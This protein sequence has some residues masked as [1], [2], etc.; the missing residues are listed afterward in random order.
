M[1]LN[2]ARRY[3]TP[4]L[5][6]QTAN[7]QKFASRK[8]RPN[9]P[10]QCVAPTTPFTMK[11]VLLFLVA[12]LPACQPMPHTPVQPVRPIS[13]PTFVR[14]PRQRS[15]TSNMS[16][17]HIVVRDVRMPVQPIAEAQVRFENSRIPPL[18]TDT[19]GY[20]RRT[21]LNPGEYDLYVHRIGYTPFRVRIRLVRGCAAWVE[22]YLTSY[23]CDIGEC[24]PMPA[25]R[26]TLSTCAR[27]V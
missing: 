21:S 10:S 24:P 27:E 15:D 2:G 12:I 11:R 3:L 20:A 23:A 4:I 25:A 7:A 17:L 5:P 18:V 16:T 14:I 9:I 22:I 8:I 26:A 13:Q 19:S 1:Q 6:L